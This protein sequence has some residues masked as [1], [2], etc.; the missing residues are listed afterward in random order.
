MQRIDKPLGEGLDL[1]DEVE[2]I[3]E[4]LLLDVTE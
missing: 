1:A 4:R 2:E 3:D